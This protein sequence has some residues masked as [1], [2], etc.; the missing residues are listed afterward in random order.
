M[1]PKTTFGLYRDDGL[2]LLRDLNR[3][4][5]KKKEKLSPKVSTTLVLVLIFKQILKK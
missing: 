1:L 4:Q 3:E 5:M 2:I